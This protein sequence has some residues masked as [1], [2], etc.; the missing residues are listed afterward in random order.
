MLE[1]VGTLRPHAGTSPRGYYIANRGFYEMVL[2]QGSYD[3]IVFTRLNERR[4]LRRMQESFPVVHV[5]EGTPR[6]LHPWSTEPF[7]STEKPQFLRATMLAEERYYI[8][9]LGWLDCRTV[10][11]WAPRPMSA[12]LWPLRAVKRCTQSLLRAMQARFQST[13]HYTIVAKYTGEAGR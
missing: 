2:R 1:Y 12:A 13:Q 4:L 9:P 11:I 5:P 3:P 10:E 6:Y 8:V 7:A